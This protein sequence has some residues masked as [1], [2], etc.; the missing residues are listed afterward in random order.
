MSP[1]NL[2]AFTNPILHLTVH[3]STGAATS[4]AFTSDSSQDWLSTNSATYHPP[5][6]RVYATT[7]FNNLW[8]LDPSTGAARKL[9]HGSWSGCVL[10]SCAGRLLSFGN[11]VCAV[12]PKDGSYIELGGQSLL[13]VWSKVTAA[14]SLGGTLFATTVANTLW[15]VDPVSGETRKVST[16]DWSRCSAL[17]GV[18]DKLY[19]FCLHL[20]IVDP[21]TGACERF[22]KEGGGFFGG[23]DKLA[24]VV[25]AV[26]VGTLIYAVNKSGKL[27][28]VDTVAKSY[29]EVASEGLGLSK[30]LV[31]FGEG[32]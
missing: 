20:W 25:G 7:T 11:K 13:D 26:A 22:N 17:V 29:R 15:A 4:A 16:D 8:E 1:V 32:L 21:T 14:T 23:G 9:S 24:G 3:P 2:L 18:G 27:F 31:A 19:A 6:Q 10:V 30:A 28:E 12:D 5:T